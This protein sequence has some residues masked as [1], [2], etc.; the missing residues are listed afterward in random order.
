MSDWLGR[1]PRIGAWSKAFVL[2]RGL[3]RMERLELREGPI[4]ERAR[5]VY[6]P[7]VDVARVAASYGEHVGTWCL[8]L[9]TARSNRRRR[10]AVAGRKAGARQERQERQ[11]RQDF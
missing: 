9:R 11:E 10:L 4:V 6:G 1:L 3:G 5:A 2:Y 7:D 8:Y